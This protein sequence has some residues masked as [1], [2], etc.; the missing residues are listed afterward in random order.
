MRPVLQQAWILLRLPPELPV[1]ERPEPPVESTATTP[2]PAPAPA[3]A[4]PPALQVVAAPEQDP[5]IVAMREE[6]ARM[7]R[8][9]ET[10]LEQL[11][12]ERLRGSPARAAVLDALTGYGCSESLARDADSKERGCCPVSERD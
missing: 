7:R 5:A 4:T 8:M 2:A 11:S 12:I 6:L 1:P 3:A 10:Q 9:M